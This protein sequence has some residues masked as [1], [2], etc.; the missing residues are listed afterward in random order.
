MNDD[1]KINYLEFQQ[2]RQQLNPDSKLRK[3]FSATIFTQLL[4]EH[5]SSSSSLI[6]S[7]G[8]K[9]SILT[10]FRYVMR[11][12]WLQ[13]ARVSLSFWDSSA[14]GYLTRLV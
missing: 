8:G 13:Q 4:S 11:K 5:Q 6:Q 12:I 7:T 9:I 2:I 10:F 1:Q 3:Y 14:N